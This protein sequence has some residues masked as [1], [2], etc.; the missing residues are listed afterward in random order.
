MAA[1]SGTKYNR[2]SKGGRL[3]HN[4]P[5]EIVPLPAENSE[6]KALG[7]STHPSGCPHFT[8]PFLLLS[9]H[10]RCSCPLN[11]FSP[12]VSFLQACLSLRLPVF[13]SLSVFD[14][15]F[16]VNGFSFSLFFFL[17]FFFLFAVLKPL[18]AHLQSCLS[19]HGLWKWMFYCLH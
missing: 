2:R 7:A 5:A 8:V 11:L 14:A 13:L 10:R 15:V 9:P 4:Q 3:I 17:L 18:G 19:F 6:N 12:L 1:V 16:C